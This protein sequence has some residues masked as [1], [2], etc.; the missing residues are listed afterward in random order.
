MARRY[1]RPSVA[2][3]TVTR[4]NRYAGECA[5]CGQTVEADAGLAEKPA[6]SAGW[7]VTHRPA[8]WA[9]SPTSGQWV[10]GCPSETRN[11]PDCD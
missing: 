7:R 8:A 11:A 9:G 10:G 4:A 3:S 6:G 2:R 1:G 5:Y